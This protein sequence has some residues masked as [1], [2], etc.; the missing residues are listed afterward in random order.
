MTPWSLANGRS[1]TRFGRRK[2][3][4]GDT[5]DALLMRRERMEMAAVL[6]TQEGQDGD[7]DSLMPRTFL[8]N[9]V[10]AINT[11]AVSWG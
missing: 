5:Q 11:L 3:K 6:L 1:T 9:G 4:K 8:L 7:G 2:R 10:G